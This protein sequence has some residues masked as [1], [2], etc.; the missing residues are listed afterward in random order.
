MG[1][2]KKCTM[3]VVKMRPTQPKLQFSIQFDLYI[4]ASEESL[5][6]RRVMIGRSSEAAIYKSFHRELERFIYRRFRGVPSSS[7]SHDWSMKYVLC[8]F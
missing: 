8:I 4:A 7:K 2:L 3:I 6:D 5:R 1:S